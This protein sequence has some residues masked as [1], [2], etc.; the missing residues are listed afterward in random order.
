MIYWDDAYSIH[1]KRVDD[2]HKRF[3]QLIQT[4]EQA[5]QG[6][7]GREVLGAILNELAD[8]AIYH[9]KM[10][11]KLFQEHAYPDRTRHMIEHAKM[12]QKAVELRT[13]FEAGKM[14]VTAELVTFMKHWLTN[15]ILESDMKL[16][17]FLK[18]KGEI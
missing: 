7:Q 13:D 8:Y 5:V 15:H 2:Q 14:V 9:F 4:M 3:F 17:E 1:N 18:E 12:K 10:E 16:G 11:E 6:R